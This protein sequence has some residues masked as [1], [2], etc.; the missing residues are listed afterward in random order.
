MKPKQTVVLEAFASALRS[1]RWVAAA[2]FIAYLM[3][4]TIL[5][6]P[7]E[8]ALVLR[9]GKLHGATREEQIRRPGLLFALPFP[10]DRVVRVPVKEEG[11]VLIDDLWKSLNEAGPLVDAIN[12]LKEGYCLTGDQNILQARLVAKYRIDDPVAFALTIENPKGLVHDAVMAAATQSI[13]AWRVDNALRLRDD[14][15]QMNLVSLVQ[16]AAQTRL[17]NA[18]CGLVLS[19]LEFKEIHPPRHL[20]IEF[21]RAQSARVAKDTR[22]REAEGFASSK[23]P[24]AEAERNRLVMEATANASSLRARATAELAVFQTLY[25]EYR[26]NPKMTSERIHREALQQM[27]SQIGKRYLVPP[28][29]PGGDLRIYVSEQENSQ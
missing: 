27:M 1:F 10:I 8:V 5:V 11:E 17:D 9:L 12:P 4:A 23:I 26:R 29:G 22:K 14:Q 2:L 20:R 25:D 15:T 24:Q 21:D 3:S 18:N 13:A 7:G 28:G 16:R 6:Q 19:A